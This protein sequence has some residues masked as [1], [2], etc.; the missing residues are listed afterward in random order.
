MNALALI[1]P[2][3]FL[4]CWLLILYMFFNVIR[5]ENTPPK[6][7]DF[8]Y[9]RKSVTIYSNLTKNIQQ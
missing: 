4:G 1:I 3:Y 2:I 9:K 8:K 7:Y 5:I 6:K